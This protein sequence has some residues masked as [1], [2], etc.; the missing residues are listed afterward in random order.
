MVRFCTRS[1]LV[2]KA[3]SLLFTS[4]RITA[5]IRAPAI[6]PTEI[7]VFKPEVMTRVSPAIMLPLRVRLPP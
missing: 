1:T 7:R 6:V 2:P 5:G 3:T 4:I